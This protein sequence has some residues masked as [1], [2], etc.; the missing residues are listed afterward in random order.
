MTDER[1]L[2]RTFLSA[3]RLTFAALWVALL[4]IAGAGATCMYTCATAPPET[5]ETIEEH[6]RNWAE[7]RTRDCINEAG[8][9]H[10][11]FEQAAR[12]HC[13]SMHP[14]I[15]LG[16]MKP[17]APGELGTTGVEGAD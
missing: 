3:S 13:L 5:P 7:Y 16:C 11:E 8:E 17:E 15:F 4:L 6:C 12:D 14:K 2:K 1:D 9:L 10:A